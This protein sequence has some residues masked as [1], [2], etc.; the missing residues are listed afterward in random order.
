[1]VKMIIA[2]SGLT[3][4]RSERKAALGALTLSQLEED[5]VTRRRGPPALHPT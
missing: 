5:V 1:M 3:F 2:L 4:W